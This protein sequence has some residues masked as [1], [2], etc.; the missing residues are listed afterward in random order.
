MEIA[1]LELTMA[2]KHI[3]NPTIVV[4]VVGWNS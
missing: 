2:L 1:V 3:K 4:S